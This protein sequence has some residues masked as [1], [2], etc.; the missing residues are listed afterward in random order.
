MMAPARSALG[1]TIR[2]PEATWALIGGAIP[3][4][5]SVLA[6]SEFLQGGPEMQINR[7]I[8]V[9]IIAAT[10]FSTAA[11]GDARVQSAAGG[12]TEIAVLAPSS[13]RSQCE[14]R[15]HFKIEVM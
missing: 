10:S 9:V 12:E 14:P 8:S 1:P 15:S 13:M 5:I 2:D 11:M 4:R 6:E 7:L 3:V